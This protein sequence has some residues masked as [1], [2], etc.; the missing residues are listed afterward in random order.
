M[1]ALLNNKHADN[2]DVP[3]AYLI[4]LTL[5]YIWSIYQ[6]NAKYFFEKSPNLHS[7]YYLWT[8]CFVFWDQKIMQKHAKFELFRIMMSS[9]FTYLSNVI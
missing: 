5:K 8:A 4:C 2:L 6:Y 9:Y 7:T 3:N 1:E